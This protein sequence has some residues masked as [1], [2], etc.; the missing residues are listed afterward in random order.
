MVSPPK[1]DPVRDA[2][3][4][5]I[6]AATSVPQL[7][8]YAETAG[9]AGS[10]GLTTAGPTLL[11]WGL[12]TG[13]PYA[14][15]GVTSL[16]AMMARTDLV[17]GDMYESYVR[18]HGEEGYVYLVSAYSLWVGVASIL[19]AVAGFGGLARSVPAAVRTGFKW[20][21]EVGVLASALPG[22]LYHHGLT[23]AIRGS[24]SGSHLGRAAA[25]VTSAFPDATG[26]VGVTNVA[27]ALS[28]PWSWD[29]DAVFVFAN[30][31]AFVML[32]RGW[33]LPRWVPPGSEVV[34]AAAAATAFGVYFDYRGG[35]VGEIPSGGGVADSGTSLFGGLARV[36]IDFL[37]ARRLLDVPLA[38]RCFGGSTPRLL[39]SATVFAGVNFLSIVAISTGFEKD[40][41][42]AW[43]APRELLAQGA[44]NVIAALVGSAPVS[45]SMSRSLVSRMTGTT[46]R[47][48]CVVTAM[49]WMCATPCMS[50]M[51][52][53][54]R[55]ALSAVI[56]SA[57]VGNVVAPSKLLAL[58]GPDLFVGL[59]TAAGSAVVSPTMG[60]VLG[61]VLHYSVR[62][63]MESKKKVA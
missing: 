63:G 53:T 31:V 4:G 52:Q 57:V 49:L 15:A 41:G 18:D 30:C 23:S 24:I 47:L 56:V 19:L 50:A 55:A 6:M 37:D 21:C 26:V 48:A 13:S 10:R 62:M 9:Y 58:R 34:I 44:S 46:S 20:G 38:E 33:L 43:S 17:P 2:I 59:M 60:F 32:A 1:F 61:C 3:S 27:Y 40:D 36:P 12:T 14:N 8:A 45:G 5:A 51:S 42:I 16:T 39:L 28:H 35:V 25:R 54:P 7:I 29:A 11:A 22:G